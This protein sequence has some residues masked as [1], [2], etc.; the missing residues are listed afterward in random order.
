MSAT[1]SCIGNALVHAP[2]RQEALGV[3]LNPEVRGRAILVAASAVARQFGVHIAL[4]QQVLSSTLE[5]RQLSIAPTSKETGVLAFN[6][7]A[8]LNRVSIHSWCWFAKLAHHLP[9]SS[10]LPPSCQSFEISIC[11][12]LARRRVW[13]S[14]QAAREASGCRCSAAERV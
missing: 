6:Q 11:R 9:S 10:T 12:W 7:S 1:F 8:S 4:Q 2:G 3:A 13:P 14:S 5:M